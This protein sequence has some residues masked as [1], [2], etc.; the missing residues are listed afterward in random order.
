[1]K[2]PW[3]G[4]CLCC[5][6]SF[7]WRQHKPPEGVEGSGATGARV[8]RGHVNAAPAAKHHLV[9]SGSEPENLGV[10]TNLYFLLKNVFLKCNRLVAKNFSEFSSEFCGESSSL[11]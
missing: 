10:V 7:R 4:L 3:P 1:M 6:C 9:R 11:S 8:H 2:G 5:S